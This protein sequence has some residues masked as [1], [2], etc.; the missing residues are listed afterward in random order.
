MYLRYREP[1]WE[2]GDFTEPQPR[3]RRTEPANS[4]SSKL[5]ESDAGRALTRCLLSSYTA[6][7]FTPSPNEPA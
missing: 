6:F 3:R 1:S 7:A 5:N 4:S 2:S